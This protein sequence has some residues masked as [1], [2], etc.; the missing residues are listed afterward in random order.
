MLAVLLQAAGCSGGSPPAAESCPSDGSSPSSSGALA[1]SEFTGSSWTVSS[2][3]TAACPGSN[4]VPDT[5]TYPATFTGYQGYL[6][7]F[8]AFPPGADPTMTPS[9]AECT[10]VL[11][12]SP[13][14]HRAT[15]F[16]G[17]VGCKTAGGELGGP[18]APFE[19]TLFEQFTA[20]TCDGHHL[21]ATIRG[22]LTKVVDGAGTTATCTVAET[23]YA[24]R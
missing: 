10:F 11:A 20:T 17:P 5:Q 4:G 6:E 7:F 15:L 13:D 18:Y 24:A 8:G 12:V 16:N 22:V 1:L 2:T 23:F 9:T 14:G 21:T 3:T 19:P